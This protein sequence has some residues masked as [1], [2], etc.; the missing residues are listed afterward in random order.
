[1]TSNTNGTPTSSNDRLPVTKTYKLFIGGKFPRSESGHS[2]KVFDAK[3]NCVANAS[4]ASRKDTRD[5]VK[6]ARGAFGAWSANTAYLRGQILYRI[7]EMLEGRREQF[8]AH[9]VEFGDT[10]DDAEREVTA[11]IDCFVYYA[12]FSDK[13]QQIV[14]AS[15][16][17][18]AP[19][20]NFSIPEPT[21]VV[22][23]IAP[24]RGMSLFGLAATI[25]PTI[26][27]G[28]TCVVVAEE[29][30]PLPAIT[31]AEVIATS[32]VPGGVVNILTGKVSDLGPVLAGHMD[33]NA[34]DMCGV[35]DD[36]VTEMETI[37]AENLKR[38]TRPRKLDAN[39]DGD[40]D[41]IT[42]FIELKTVWHPIGV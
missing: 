42:R 22:G 5:A 34:I 8:V 29:N 30:N 12:G 3:G 35:P 33:V 40:L 1:M 39:R 9:L 15:N 2:Y 14:G 4:K 24:D 11:S 26:V 20:F 28:N 32:D 31:F 36:L 23:I 41:A 6:A 25:A 17:V 18:G 16:P 38:V 13:F 21:G 19:Y 10:R 37:A 27:S 7:A